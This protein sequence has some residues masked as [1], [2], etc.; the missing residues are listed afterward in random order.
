MDINLVPFLSFVLITTFTPG[1]NNISST[2]MGVL[3]GYRRSLK[4]LLGIATG[5][6]F[7]MLLCGLVSTTL[8]RI[9][10]SFEWVLRL[11][12]AAYII[13]LAIETLRASYN[14]SKEDQPL[15]GFMR[16]M[17]LQ[18]L[19]AKMIIYG[20]TLYATFLGPLVNQPFYLVIS[21]V[22]LASL[23]FLSVSTW[24]I[25][26]A[27]IRTY[28]RLPKVQLWVNI[29]LASLLVYAAIELSGLFHS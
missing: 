1:P 6:F 19:N 11:I 24:T 7:I 23:A 8:L 12:G 10:P 25:F 26:G 22:G 28:L 13:F 9:F 5:F 4:Y 17:L 14:F 21:A 2:S 27:G 15:M 29:I 16:G 18:L 3:Y 20:I